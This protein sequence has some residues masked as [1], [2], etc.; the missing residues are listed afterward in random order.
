[1]QSYF[2]FQEAASFLEGWWLTH[3]AQGREEDSCSAVADGEL[4]G[5]MHLPGSLE[6]PGRL[7]VDE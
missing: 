5:L 4:C 7:A 1:M 6:L 3:A 2:P